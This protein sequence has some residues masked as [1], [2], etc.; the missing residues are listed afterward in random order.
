MFMPFEKGVSG[1]VNG[2]RPGTANKLTRLHREF[3]QNLLDKQQGKIRRELKKLEGKEYLSI[4]LTLMEFS[5]PKLNR[6]ELNTNGI[7][8]IKVIRK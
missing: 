1:N 4:V 5:I 6:T 8:R 2:R 7:T 3:V